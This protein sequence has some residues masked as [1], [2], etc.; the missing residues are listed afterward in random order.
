MS[1]CPLVW[2]FRGLG[3][4]NEINR[5]P[6]RCLQI[7]Y[8]DKKSTFIELLGIDNSASIQQHRQN[9]DK[10]RNNAHDTLPLVTSSKKP[11]EFKL[12]GSKNFRNFAC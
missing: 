7:N 1:Y 9:R 11:I 5:L 3:K 2:K 6:E 8:S 10:L 4:N 12:L